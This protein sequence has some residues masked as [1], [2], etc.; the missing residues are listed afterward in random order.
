MCQKQ[1]YSRTIFFKRHLANQ[2]R[3]NAFLGRGILVDWASSK[4]GG[5]DDAI[6]GMSMLSFNTENLKEELEE[7]EEKITYSTLLSHIDNADKSY[8]EIRKQGIWKR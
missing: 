5:N 8:N 3:L 4:D 2:Q 7:K 1:C 6:T